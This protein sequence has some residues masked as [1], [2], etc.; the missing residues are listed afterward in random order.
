MPPQPNRTGQA[1]DTISPP[2]RN[3][4]CG[5]VPSHYVN[6]GKYFLSQSPPRRPAGHR[7]WDT[8]ALAMPSVV[9]S[10]GQR[11]ATRTRTHRCIGGLSFRGGREPGPERQRRDRRT[12]SMRSAAQLHTVIQ[13]SPIPSSLH[14]D[15]L[16]P[17]LVTALKYHNPHGKKSTEANQVQCGHEA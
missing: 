13:H 4:D 12:G 17:P 8:V 5:I 10:R 16:P 6:L 11:R 15:V 9:G 2:Y 3:T 14:P 1:P 7:R